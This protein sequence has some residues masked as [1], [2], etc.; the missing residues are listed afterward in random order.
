[1]NSIYKSLTTNDVSV[2]PF[3][4]YKLITV[5]SASNT[6][7][8]FYAGR[9]E[10]RSFN[11]GDSTDPYVS[12]LPTTTHSKYK[13]LV[14]DSLN[15]LFYRKYNTDER[16]ITDNE[17]K[18]ELFDVV[19]C[20]SIPRSSV[21]IGIKPESVN[22]SLTVSASTH[23]VID[24]GSGNLID[25]TLSASFSFPRADMVEGIV[26]SWNFADA[27]IFGEKHISGSYVR[28]RSAHLNHAKLN[29]VLLESG[30]FGTYCFFSSSIHSATIPHNELYNFRYNEDFSIACL[31]KIPIKSNYLT[32]TAEIIIAKNGRYSDA[33]YQGNLPDSFNPVQVNQLQSTYYPFTISEMKSGADY[34]KIV[35]EKFDGLH[36]ASVTSSMALNDAAEHFIMCQRSGSLLQLFIDGIPDNTVADTTTLQ[37]HNSCDVFVAKKGDGTGFFNGYINEIEIRAGSMETDVIAEYSQRK[38]AR[39]FNYYVGNVF[40]NYGLI[41]F[42]DNSRFYRDLES[43]KNTESAVTTWNLSVNGSN[44]ISEHE[45]ICSISPY[46][47]NYTMNR[48]T[49]KDERNNRYE[50]LGFVSHS[51]F[52]PYVTTVGLYNDKN[53]LLVVG[54]LSRPIPRL[55]RIDQTFIL[56]FDV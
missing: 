27:Y 42:T 34:G 39:T 56:R 35:F 55:K 12:A 8:D 20:F 30:D 53:E 19:S 31:L 47:F 4:T 36:K 46:E 44:V 16:I 43:Q 18:K 29:S 6:T 50:Y 22:I 1:M 37:C 14:H 45:Y 10:S 38:L 3:S 7:V 33:Q 49:L 23:S 41:T 24:D 5:V 13:Y 26:G 25:A 15:H 11:L 51:L 2:T 17:D 32:S 52:S 40:Y 9:F 48:S 28:D 54:K 21:G